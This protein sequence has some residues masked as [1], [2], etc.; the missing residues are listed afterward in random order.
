[1][2]S[3]FMDLTKMELGKSL[4]ITLS[5]RDAAKPAEYLGE[6][7]LTAT[8]WPRSQEDKDQ[9]KLIYFCFLYFIYLFY[10]KI[11]NVQFTMKQ[12]LNTFFS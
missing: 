10:F 2:G 5:L 8:L 3:A 4:E 9:V 11:K 7:F 1:M 12:F 6:L